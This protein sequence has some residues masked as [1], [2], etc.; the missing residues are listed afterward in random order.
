[1]RGAREEQGERE[2]S[3]SHRAIQRMSS[4]KD[5]TAARSLQAGGVET[6]ELE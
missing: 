1:M 6:L 5:R 2:H 4:W 3:K